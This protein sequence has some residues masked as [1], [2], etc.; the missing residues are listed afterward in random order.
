MK[1][2]DAERL[3]QARAGVVRKHRAIDGHE[4]TKAA[5]RLAAKVA[6]VPAAMELG[7]ASCDDVCERMAW[8]DEIDGRARGWLARGLG[9]LE[10][11]AWR[12]S[13]RPNRNSSRVAVF[14]VRD[15]IDAEAW[16]REHDRRPAGE[17]LALFTEGID[18]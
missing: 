2:I 15:R 11:V 8:P 14:R 9:F 10:E 6:L 4:E 1:S 13:R 12:P 3:R 17:Q 18:G 5:L 16:L 7:Q